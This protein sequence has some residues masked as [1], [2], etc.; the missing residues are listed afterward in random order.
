MRWFLIAPKLFCLRDD[1]LTMA[2]G[3]AAD[4]ADAVG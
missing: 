3:H 2:G 4:A 1:S